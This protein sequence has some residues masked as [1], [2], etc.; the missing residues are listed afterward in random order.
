[1]KKTIDSITKVTS[2]CN[3]KVANWINSF[4]G[5]FITGGTF[6]ASSIKV[7]EA[8]KI[9]ENTQRDLNIALINELSKIFKLMNIDTLDV[10]NAASSKWNFIKFQPG[11]VGGHCIGVDPYYLTFK[12]E[13]LGYKPEMILAGRQ[14]NDGMGKYITSQ[15]SNALKKQNIKEEEAEGLILGLTFKENCPDVRNT[16]VYDIYEGML[17][18]FKKVDISEPRAIKEDIIK[19]YN[20][21]PIEIDKNDLNKYDIVVLAVNHS[22]YAEL[23]NGDW[24][25]QNQVVFDVK[26]SINSNKVLS[27]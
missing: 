19:V 14:I 24:I 22:E 27:L 2:G 12:S 18:K 5:S 13:E 26:S 6:Q 7:A 16:K 3:R 21:T 20:K 17:K 15:I 10:I 25:S 23:L 4:Y 9:I 11:L 8:A 1:M